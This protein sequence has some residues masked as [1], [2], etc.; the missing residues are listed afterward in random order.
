MLGLR[1]RQPPALC[2]RR[3]NRGFIA[4]AS[5][6]QLPQVIAVP[7][8]ARRQRI[9][10]PGAHDDAPLRQIGDRAGG[11]AE[12]LGKRGGGDGVIHARASIAL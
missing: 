7:A 12:Q 11:D 9:A 3:R 10:A 2:R 1:F 8:N 4:S 5:R 6:R